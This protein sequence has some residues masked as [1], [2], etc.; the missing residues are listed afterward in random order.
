[1]NSE[2]LLFEL[3]KNPFLLAPMAGITDSVFRHYMRRQGAGIVI[4]ELISANGLL[5]DSDKTK[6]L[7]RFCEEERPVGI[8]IFGEDEN[9]L[10]NA[11]QYVEGLG[12]DFV[13]INLGCPVKKVVKKGAG[14]ALLKEPLKLQQIFRSIKN[15]ITI[16]LTI[17]IRTGWDHDNKNALEIT[18][19]AFNEGV[20]WVAIHGRTRSQGYE[21]VA[22]WDYIAGVKR[23]S[24]L[25]IIGNGDITSAALAVGRLN[26]SGCDGVMIGR[27]CLKNPWIFRQ[28]LELYYG[29]KVSALS[30]HYMGLFH[31]IKEEGEQYYDEKYLMLQ[32]RKLG[33]WYSAGLPGSSQFRKDIFAVRTV[34]D[35][36]ALIETYYTNIQPQVQEDTSHEAFLMGGHG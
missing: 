23:N 35:T 24:P 30:D 9:A 8:Q 32:L 22:D 31:Y 1:M 27:G 28:S 25:P 14:S 33:A 12:A 18:N 13:D 11:A 15:K 21:G 29:E 26:D 36:F 4:S 19:I 10:V 34:E 16:P 20:T 3:K 17:K 2:Q 7:M 6:A 5:Y